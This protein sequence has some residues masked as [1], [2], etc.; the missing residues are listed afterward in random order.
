MIRNKD[1]LILWWEK[2]K[3]A[4]CRWQESRQE[5][6]VQKR[7]GTSQRWHKRR[8]W[9]TCRLYQNTMTCRCTNAIVKSIHWW[10]SFK[11]IKAFSGLVQIIILLRVCK[12]NITVPLSGS[13]ISHRVRHTVLWTLGIFYRQCAR[14]GLFIVNHFLHF[15]QCD[16]L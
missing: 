16:S 13:S 5:D 12:C 14:A 11:T 2:E 9:R 7:R 6:Q 15:E 4:Q 3:V 8:K 1:I 10:A